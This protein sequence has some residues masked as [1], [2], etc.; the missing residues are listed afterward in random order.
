MTLKHL[1]MT[2]YTFAALGAWAQ[3][4]GQRI[5]IISDIHLLSPQLVTPG[6]AID[7]ADQHEI[8]MMALS[9]DIMEAICD[10]LIAAKPSLVLI[11]GDLTHNGELLSHKRVAQH[12][13]RL[14]QHGIASL[15]IPGNH[16]I[17]NPYA[18]RFDGDDTHPTP[19]VTR[20]EFA[21]IYHD[22][23][24]GDDSQRDTASLSYCC[25]PINGLVVLGIDTNLDEQNRLKSRG[26]S[27]NTYHNAG[28]I[29]PS[30][31]DWAVQQ[32][33][34]ATSQ[35][36]LVV[37]MMHHHLIPHFDMEERFL[38]NYIVQDNS[39][40]AER[41]LQAGVH[42]VFTG[43]L[44]VTDAARA[45][46]TTDHN[47]IV[48]MATGSAITYPFA[49]RIAQLSIDKRQMSIDTHWVTSTPQC[50]HLREL[51]RQRVTQA[52]PHIANLISNKLWDKMSG[53]V[54]QMKYLLE[55]D[56]G[57]VN[58]PQS[59]SQTSDLMLRHLS[60]VLTRTLLAVVEG[61]EQEKQPEDIVAQGKQSVKALIQDVAPQQADNLWN[62]FN[63]DVYPK[64]EPLVRSLLEDRNGVNTTH[65]S[66]TNDLRLIVDL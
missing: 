52:T 17:N 50:P 63:Q 4:N 30:T 36:K 26:D 48:E 33:Q 27:V 6:T 38:S 21:Q 8:K 32:A 60:E 20:A 9:D 28:A 10:S 55:A 43:H 22:Y 7:N 1:L 23:G 65:E 53:R 24:Y 18:M 54:Q 34:L 2:L 15:I 44:H 14:R 37:A 45:L 31:L 5:A 39:H 42:L 59:A 12:L 66:R 29:K 40:A 49:M 13:N 61:N 41:L 11:T 56:G 46:N 25:E 64:L 3:P 47:G 57:T 35:G 58:L 16:D 19:T 62:F 51:G